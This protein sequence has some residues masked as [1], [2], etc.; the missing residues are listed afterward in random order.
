MESVEMERDN[1]FAADAA[2]HRDFRFDSTVA[3]VFDDMITRSVPFYSELQSMTAELADDFAVSGTDVYDL[4]CSTGTTLIELD[5][6][7]NSEIRL[8]GVDSSNEMLER[9]RQRLAALEFRHP[10][11]FRRA[12]L[13]NGAAVDNASVVVMVLTLQ[14]IRPLRRQHLI[15]SI[16]DGLNEQG[17]LILVEK[18]T[19]EDSMLNRLF[20]KHY[21]EFKE[22]NGY[23]TMEI[24]QKREALENILIPYRLDENRELLVSSGFKSCEEFFRWYNFSGL[25]ALK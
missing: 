6:R 2:G 22:E 12:D 19:V 3:A 20:I 18:L 17:C 14:F 16:L 7:I 4:G 5:R 13:H 10:Y 1:L 24:A 8:I 15:R 11:A 25:I 9:G 21:H 23:S